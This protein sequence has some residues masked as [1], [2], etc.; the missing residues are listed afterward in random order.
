MTKQQREELRIWLAQACSVGSLQ[1][2]DAHI[3][4]WMMLNADIRAHRATEESGRAARAA[5]LSLCVVDRDVKPEKSGAV[6][7]FG[8]RPKLRGER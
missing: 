5:A 4:V 2:T 1:V 3:E 6:K 7:M 8:P